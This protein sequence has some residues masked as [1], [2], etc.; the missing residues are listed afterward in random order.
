[1]QHALGIIIGWQ[2]RS[3]ISCN[4]YDMY[5]DGHTRRSTVIICEWPAHILGYAEKLFYASASGIAVP[6]YNRLATTP[7]LFWWRSHIGHIAGT[8]CFGVTLPAIR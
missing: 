8:K 1:M 2:Y 4:D 7:T 3:E 5:C 6:L